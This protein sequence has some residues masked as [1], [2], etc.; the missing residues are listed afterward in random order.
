ME[1]LMPRFII[2]ALFLLLVSMSTFSFF[3]IYYL[4]HIKAIHRSKKAMGKEELLSI[5]VAYFCEVGK[6]PRQEDAYFISPLE[7][8]GKNGVVVAIS[9]GMGGLK[10]GDEI[11]NET[12][13][14]IERLCPLSF[15]GA[16]KTSDDIRKI[17]NRIYEQY[18]LEG[19]ATL[20][21]V[22]IYNNYMN[23][24]SVGDSDI[25]LVRNGQAT[26]LNPRQNYVSVLIKKLVRG[27]KTTH[28]AYANNKSR[29][30]V[31]FIGNQNPRVLYTTAPIRLYDSDTV[32]VSSD[33]LT[34]AIP[35]NSIPKYIF[36]NAKNIALN[37]KNTVKSR[38]YPK[39]DNYT[40]VIIS[41][42]RGLL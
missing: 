13:K 34:D 10:Y 7:E 18:R 23:F 12:V 36:G 9:D 39:Q 11:S 20:A 21:M 5:D 2:L 26:I 28:D 14:Q 29:A 40:S 22:H 3:V 19:G 42:K 1:E 32:I 6:R 37:L 31:E 16:E 30:L 33:G 25:I 35:W 41:L 4:R 8:F 38:S 27:N 24:Y 17:S 15:F